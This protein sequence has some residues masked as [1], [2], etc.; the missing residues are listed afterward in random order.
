[1]FRLFVSSTFED[2]H[3]ERQALHDQVFPDLAERCRERGARFQ[4][5]DLRWGISQAA[6]RDYR[7]TEIC[8]EE[9][10]RCQRQTRRP[11]FL[12]LLGDRYGWRP[13]PARI[14]AAEFETII[15]GLA[16]SPSERGLVERW[17]SRDD[18]AAPPE[19]ALR[20]G[21]ENFYTVER[22]L[23][24]ALRA[25][26]NG[27]ALPAD[28]RLCYEGSATHLEIERGVFSVPDAREHVV[29]VMR[30]LDTP[31][32]PFVD[33]LP[34]GRPDEDARDR[35]AALRDQLKQHLSDTVVEYRTTWTPGGPLADY[36]EMLCSAV[37]D[38]LWSVISLELEAAEAL[39]AVTEEVAAHRSFARG[40]VASDGLDRPGDAIATVLSY[41]SSETQSPLIV[42]GAGGVGKTTLVAQVA[43]RLHADADVDAFVRF[44]GVSAE[45]ASA[46]DLLA[47]L[48]RE[49]SRHF[50]LDEDPPSGY[51]ALVSHLWSRLEC[52]P[53]SRR[54]VVIVDG[55]DL[56]GTR[57]ASGRL[58]W[59]PSLLPPRV[60]VIVAAAPG[61]ACDTLLGL[62]HREVLKLDPLS[63]E[64]AGPILDRWLAERGRALQPA[65]RRLVL[66][67]F[68]VTG[69]PLHLRL[70]VEEATRWRSDAAMTETQLADDVPGVVRGLFA[71]LSND[72]EHGPTLVARAVTFLVCGKSGLAEDELLSLLGG[73]TDVIADVRRRFPR[74][75]LTDELPV[76][77]WSRL[78]SDLAPYLV[79]RR[80]DGAQLLDFFHRLFNEVVN[81][82]RG[83]AE[84]QR[85]HADLAEFFSVQ[86][87][88]GATPNLRALSEIPYQLAAAGRLSDL[89]RVL[90]NYSFLETKLGAFGPQSLI[91][92][93]DLARHRGDDA[94][95][96]A[97]AHVAES[98]GLAAAVLE[99]RPAELPA[100][101]HG[102]L[103]D[104][105]DEG[106]Q[107][108]LFEA[109]RGARRPWLRPL[110][111]SLSPPG[112]ALVRVIHTRGGEIQAIALT[113]NGTH[114]LAACQ[115]GTIEV[116]DLERG[117]LTR[118]LYG[119]GVF[120]RCVAVAPDGH[121]AVS[122]GRARPMKEGQELRVWELGQGR[123]IAAFDA[124]EHDFG[125]IAVLPDGERAV[126]S[127]Y[128]ATVRV[129]DLQDGH[130]IHVLRGHAWYIR[131][132]SV[133]AD[134]KLAA[135]GADDG[136]IRIWN[137]ERGMLVRTL[138][139]DHPLRASSPEE[140]A[141][142][143]LIGV[144]QVLGVAL[145]PDGRELVSTSPQEGLWIWDVEHGGRV[146]QLEAVASHPRI[147]ADG[148]RLVVL[149]DG[150][151]AIQV[152]DLP[153][154][155]VLGHTDPLAHVPTGLAVSEDGCTAVTSAGPELA[156]WRLDRIDDRSEGRP[157]PASAVA[158][159]DPGIA[160]VATSSS[161]EGR[162]LETGATLWRRTD[163]GA[164]DLAEVP[165]SGTVV[166]GRID[167]AVDVLDAASGV[168]S[169]MPDPTPSGKRAPVDAVT[170]AADGRFAVTAAFGTISVWDLER[171]QLW[172]QFAS[173]AHTVK[174]LAVTPD[175]SMVVSLADRGAYEGDHNLKR[176]DP[177]SGR[178]VSWPSWWERSERRGRGPDLRSSSSAPRQVRPLAITSDG[179]L[180]VSALWGDG[181]RIWDLRADLEP[182][183]LSADSRAETVATLSGHRALAPERYPDCAMAI[184]DLD[185]G[186]RLCTLEGGPAARVT[187]LSVSADGSRAL[188][189]SLQ[190]VCIW[191]LNKRVPIATLTL[192]DFAE[193]GK[194][195]ADG[196]TAVVGDRRSVHVLRLSG[197]AN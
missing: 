63:P 152:W 100:Q 74:S 28:R 75:P 139:T 52:V 99:L 78:L 189:L 2:L 153:E 127:S 118:T 186:E 137:L 166:V 64:D 132:L 161:L 146:A 49:I 109:P 39:D 110:T 66:E 7:T 192:D 71:R 69:L 70:A 87:P 181:L 82:D 48:A 162:S 185:A 33:V 101:L 85:R 79:E 54:A 10:A 136:T 163:L 130:A 128:D 60:R 15:D 117:E 17:Y 150:L 34:D 77:V 131:A 21:G 195:S 169:S 122:G 158:L 62:P 194:L 58:D 19:Y 157:E 20:R 114:A 108:L 121:R 56:L 196:R 94:A 113:P 97:L 5:I 135:S 43:E 95:G 180:A 167:G 179:A 89:A 11:N 84:L 188:T 191:D 41:V 18:N 124:H 32:A 68:S 12:V 72:A 65:Q 197:A 173:P 88:N 25:G 174:A 1:V 147:C 155:R 133:A 51:D 112:A 103:L 172:H 187:S 3:V 183:T 149:N 104:V 134:G 31:M 129:W 22:A 98:L 159:A 45:S 119:H 154:R 143:S 164:L 80:A 13:L 50:D 115:D 67:R 37:S 73:D 8:L 151:R 120:A 46:A 92:D 30:S 171:H 24:G 9:I 165:R 76:A 170:V 29:C 96:D 93:F 178:E 177:K 59:L 47:G 145:T 175:G 42:T 106:I 55:V 125:E 38:R 57:G 142:G 44:V 61:P 126:S 144:T 182:R 90:T 184:W 107:R 105:R 40:R 83:D 4:P 102:R 16:A 36:L 160:V 148:R 156:V 138:E 176:W 91:D 116:R 193:V 14:P 27:K 81:E 123:P 26:L 140:L 6:A 168:S 141:P 53:E 86:P 190:I 23:H 35:L 111:R